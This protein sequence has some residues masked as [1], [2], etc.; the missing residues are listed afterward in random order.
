MTQIKQNPQTLSLFEGLFIKT[1]IIK[2]M[3]VDGIEPSTTCLKGRCSTPELHPHNTTEVVVQVK[4]KILI[5]IHLSN[6]I[7]INLE[8]I[9]MTLK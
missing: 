9:Y 4:P 3:R 5:S 7:S 8:I 2:K 1:I 6:F